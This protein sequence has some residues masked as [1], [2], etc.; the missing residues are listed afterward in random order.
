VK[1]EKLAELFLDEHHSPDKPDDGAG[2]FLSGDRL[3]CVASGDVNVFVASFSRTSGRSLGPH[4]FVAA[5][6]AGQFIFPMPA[7]L[8][9]GDAVHRLLAVPLPGAELRQSRVSWL[10]AVA[11]NDAARLGFEEQIAGLLAP[12]AREMPPARTHVL[13]GTD[14]E[15]QRSFQFF[16]QAVFRPGQ[17]L[18]WVRLMEGTC[19]LNGDEEQLLLLPGAEFPVSARMWLHA[20]D[21]VSIECRSTAEWL[22][23]PA[24]QTNLDA[25]T[26]S[27]LRAVLVA[28]AFE[29][30]RKARRRLH[31][32]ELEQVAMHGVVQGLQSLMKG[33]ESAQ[34]VLTATQDCAGAARLSA[35][36]SVVRRVARALG[37]DIDLP[38]ADERVG[39]DLEPRSVGDAAATGPGSRR[40][41]HPD[42]PAETPLDQDQA[43]DRAQEQA[44]E[45]VPEQARAVERLL[46][47]GN[48]FFRKTTLEKGW[49]KHESVPMIAFGKE[50]G[51]PVAL[52]HEQGRWS[53]FDPLSN[54][55][56]PVSPKAAGLLLPWAYA[57]YPGLPPRT[58]GRWD[59]FRTAF[60]GAR[61]DIRAAVLLGL[62]GGL[63]ALV[64][65]R[66]T[67]TLFNAVIPSA[68]LLQL[69]QIGVIMVAAA[70]AGCL[71][72][73]CRS[74]LLLRVRTRANY[75]LQP[76]LWSR[77][78]TLP[79]QFFSR[80]STGELGQRVMSVEAMRNAL[81]DSTVLSIMALLFSLPSLGLMLFYSRPLTALAVLAT[82]VYLA[83][84]IAAVR[85]LWRAQREELHVDGLLSGFSLQAIAGV[86]KIKMSTSEN[87]AFARWAGLFSEKVHWRSRSIGKMNTMTVL[88]AT[89]PPLMLGVFFLAV[90]SA[91]RGTQ[92]NV[93]EFL[94]FN[95]AFTILV[96]ALTGFVGVLPELLSG[97]AQYQ[98]LTP[99]LEAVPE[100][101]EE[102]RP[103]GE[104]DGH[105]EL[106]NVTFR[107]H[108]DLPSVL[109][110]VT[111]SA[112]PGEFVAIV[113]PSGA[114]KST[115]AR[116]LLGFCAPESG[117]VYFGG[118]DLAA[119]N[120][121][122]VRRRIGV[123]LQ[124]S[125]L[126]QGSIYDNI[127]G[128][129]GMSH[130]QA[131]EAAEMAGCAEDIRAMPMGMH[132][133]VT[134]ALV[135]GGQR[136]RLLIARALA[137]RPRMI[138]FDEATSALD[139][140][141]QAH[142]ADRLDRLNATR[143]VIAHRL[144]T[145]VRADRIYVLDQGRIVQTGTFKELAD[146]PG[147][148]QRLVSRQMA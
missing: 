120:P 107:Y 87:R 97:A 119:V 53:L 92:L 115:I 21:P 108:P 129:S 68:D 73:M 82:I 63:M 138:I 78:L 124:G 113:G 69:A 42:H 8:E 20:T 121:R 67:S 44:P 23:G 60:Q 41:E 74:L 147:L 75:H 57:V 118:T 33:E 110:N 16:A 116:L 96:T 126:V 133:Y 10:D 79:V 36:G 2:F 17:G 100:I 14:L 70:L 114:G 131:W 128:V 27:Y 102:R 25:V 12:F 112:T 24:L 91:W 89:F 146:Q 81:N 101:P 93:G 51:Q 18:L 76:A 46:E 71:F 142:I 22:A 9:I 130:E 104:L 62:L 64:P 31:L 38:V 123:V 98:R 80:Y 7:R 85:T 40:G 59:V 13:T 140:E 111:I 28:L 30:Q 83:L 65:A 148:F 144:S 90:G 61:A 88:T 145:I 109:R 106:R 94:A 5:M 49:W 32:A 48:L 47:H 15:R 58:L 55:Q 29:R 19:L 135:S 34:E 45:Q 141:T 56:E 39:S 1:C 137:R 77:L 66:L 26:T 136:Q 3:H 139:N 117:G 11:G 143:I 35:S 37:M 50:D 86:A 95:S 99:I 72:E 6:H 52:V 122:D 4:Q 54:C 43:Q 125:G 134:G 127:A 132:T 84:L 103:V 105:L